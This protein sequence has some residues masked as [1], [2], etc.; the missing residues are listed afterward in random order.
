MS[1]AQSRRGYQGDDK[2][3]RAHELRS[4]KTEASAY[5][6]SD[7][8][9]RVFEQRLDDL[10]QLS[11]VL[12]GNH[13]EAERCFVVG[14]EESIHASQVFRQWAHSWAK[15]SIIQ[16][17][18]RALDPHPTDVNSFPPTSTKH[19]QVRDA[20]IEPFDINSILALEAFERFVFV[21][22]VL[23]QYTDRECAILLNCPFQEVSKARFRAY[24]Q[25]INLHRE[26]PSDESA[27]NSLREANR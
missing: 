16:N 14:F 13:E 12:T 15:R 20:R 8:F 18:I 2:M 3:Q 22:T 9:C 23:E 21:L 27:N 26:R 7:D 4:R 10:Y 5:A 24:E 25:V 1:L 17:A 19:S 11:F 6:T